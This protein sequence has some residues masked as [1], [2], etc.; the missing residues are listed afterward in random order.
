MILPRHETMVVSEQQAKL[1]DA[2]RA[3]IEALGEDPPQEKVQEIYDAIFD[4]DDFKR[5]TAELEQ[6]TEAIEA[7]RPRDRREPSVWVYLRKS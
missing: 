4:R 3:E 7:L 2:A 5:L 6:L 1:W